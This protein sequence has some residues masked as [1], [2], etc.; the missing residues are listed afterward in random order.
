V[1]NCALF[2]RGIFRI[3]VFLPFLPF[4]L[5]GLLVRIELPGDNGGMALYLDFPLLFAAPCV[6]V[7]FIGEEETEPFPLKT[8]KAL[9][10]YF[11][12]NHVPGFRVEPFLS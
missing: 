7:A 9:L 1:Y 12:H 11:Q 3:S 8:D 4:L 5:S 6:P 2:Q 10:L